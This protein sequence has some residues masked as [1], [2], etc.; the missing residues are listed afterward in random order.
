M[1]TVSLSLESRVRDLL[2]TADRQLDS[3][4][5]DAAIDTYRTALAAL[6]SEAGADARAEIEGR[7]SSAVRVR[8]I[9]ARA[10]GALREARYQ[11]TA[12][13]LSEAF[14]AVAE[15]LAL[16]PS[17]QPAAQLRDQLVAAMPGLALAPTPVQPAAPLL[18]TAPGDAPAPW[19]G[20]APPVEKPAPWSADT[21]SAEAPA[22]SGTAA[23]R[24]AV[25]AP[26]RV[27]AAPA[28]EPAPSGAAAARAAVRAP[29]RV[30]AAPAEEP[31]PSSAAAARAAVRA[32]FRVTA[33]PAEQ[34]A[35]PKAPA[36]VS[37][38][39][40]PVEEP[41]AEAQTAPEPDT[42]PIEPPS[43]QLIEDS[44]WLERP[45][46]SESL[47]EPPLSILDATPRPVPPERSRVAINLLGLVCCL[48][49]FISLLISH[50]TPRFSAPVA[51]PA[52]SVPSET[53]YTPGGGVSAPALISQ[54]EPTYTEEARQA[55]LQGAVILSG[56]IDPSGNAVNLRVVQ[57]LGMGLD[58]RAIEA[59]SHWRFAPGMKDGRPVT[60]AT[61]LQ[62]NFRLP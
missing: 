15:A 58:A 51:R 14:A 22:P 61:R 6:S 49:G 46:D 33:A 18:G 50:H 48:G 34:P 16:D 9:S 7:L 54:V 31:A 35:P 27:T 60:V 47:D 44:P 53:V 26:F 25:R 13:R 30:T 41:A 4:A 19:S 37:G 43:F 2:S 24:A 11:Q 52:D 29:F 38:A 39:A 56:A 1:E 62:V 21:S 36:P 45:R 59:V 40:A 5:Y 12:G 20:A 42:R 57:R 23:A 8:D 28:E 17:N 55:N 3:G 32:P 10:A